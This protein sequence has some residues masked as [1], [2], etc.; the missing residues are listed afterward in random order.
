MKLRLIQTI[1]G[2]IE[3]LGIC[4]L[5]PQVDW[6]RSRLIEIEKAEDSISALRPYAEELRAIIARMGS[7]TDLWLEPKGGSGMSEDAANSRKW[8]LADELDEI[9]GQILK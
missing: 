4:G 2:I 9:T 6:L 5:V 1:Q 8:E 3:L 7:L